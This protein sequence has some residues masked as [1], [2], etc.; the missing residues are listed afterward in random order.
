VEHPVTEQVTGIDLVREQINIASGK[1]IKI[2]K[3][4]AEGHS[5]E[6]RIN[7]EDPANHF[8]PS[9]GKITEFHQPGGFGVRVD[10]HAYAGYIIP[11]Y[12]DSMVAKLIT[13]ADTRKEAIARMYRALDEFVIEGVQTTIPFHKKVMHHEKFI[14]GNFD[15][16]FIDRSGLA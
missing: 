14:E 6:C 2:K 13:T 1:K 10:T 3:V 15:T 16:G 8:S 12:Y 5:I 4:K 9:P 11:Q 7:A